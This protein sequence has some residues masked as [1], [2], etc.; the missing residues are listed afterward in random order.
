MLVQ[1][2]GVGMPSDVWIRDQQGLFNGKYLDGFFS[3][4]RVADRGS[5]NESGLHAAPDVSNLLFL[6]RGR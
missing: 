1:L 5:G 3:A 2:M 4:N 6:G